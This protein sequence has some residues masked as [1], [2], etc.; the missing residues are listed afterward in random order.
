MATTVAFAAALASLLPHTWQLSRRAALSGALLSLRLPNHAAAAD[1]LTVPASAI[2][3]RMCDTTA[4]MEATM[5][6]AADGL[7]AGPPITREEISYSVNV[8]LQT[9]RLDTMP[10][11]SEAADTLRGV[12]IIAGVDKSE[13]TRDEFVSMAKQ[14]ARARDEIDK[15]FNALSEDQQEEGRRVIRKMQA[16]LDERKPALAAE[17]EKLR[18]ARARIADEQDQQPAAEPARRKKTLA[19]L[20]AAQASLFGTPPQQ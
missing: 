19:E 4:R 12:K 6:R 18:V 7:E 16:V 17:K 8:L 20:E 14:Y 15:A 2:L 9:S 13:I 5:N 10:D 1:E 3:L 11:A